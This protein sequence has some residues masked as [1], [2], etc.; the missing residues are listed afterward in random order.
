M[1]LTT[2]FTGSRGPRFPAPDVARGL[3][4]LFIALANI[5]FWVITTRS[6][7]PGD[8]ADTAWLWVR[9]LLVDH[10]AYPL[11]ALL[12]GFGLATMINRRIASGTA[13]RL[14][15]LPGVDAGCEPTP[16]EV[17]W[18][19]EQA[20][21]DA[22]RLVRRRGLWMILFGAAHAALF[23]GDIIG[24][25]G[26]VAVVFAG[27]LARKHWKRAAVVSAVLT[28]L[29]ITTMYNMGRFMAAQGLSAAAAQTEAT[30]SSSPLSQVVA[31]VTS[32]GGNTV[33]TA[34]LS[35]VVPAMFL[36]AR[37]A[38]TD[39]IT[40]P[41]RHRRLLVAVG[42]IGLGIGAAGGVG[43]AIW[44]TGGH[45]AAWAAPLHEVTGLAGACGWLALL[46]LYAGGPT[47]DGRLTGLRWLLASVGRRSMTAYLAQTFL[48]ATIFLV[49][50]ALTGISLHLGEARAA[51]IALAVWVVTVGL[52]A[53][54]EYGGHAG[55]FETLLRT[56]VARSE[57]S[58]RLPAPPAPVTPVG[59][60]VSPGAYELVR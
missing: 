25:Y 55:P 1:N 28:A 13:A 20:T 49:V 15:T 19:R 29:V 9:T 31:S 2:S 23:S 35:M 27:W 39:L 32:W 11:F 18:A 57:R 14:D 26:L 59:R 34:L 4:L 45:L 41:E 56:A 36:G 52:C 40:H 38:D 8:A 22:R 5:P 46:A 33:A 53:V 48:F 47:S 16:Q 17:A 12:F 10:R 50:P 7:A 44:F 42:L 37:L 30:G 58:R 54:M 21:V 3:M 43:Y 6:S 60:A 24:T 51:G